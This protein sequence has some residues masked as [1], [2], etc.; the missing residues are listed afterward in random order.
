MPGDGIR[1]KGRGLIQVT[2]KANYAACSV[3]LRL[4]LIEQPELLA[5]TPHCVDS[6]F[7]FWQK[8]NLNVLADSDDLLAIT[9]II[10]G[11]TNGLVQRGI[12]LNRAKATFGI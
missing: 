1:Y 8:S 9:K 11:G 12:Y 2:G 5:K 6:A 10:N 3:A 4:P 7:W